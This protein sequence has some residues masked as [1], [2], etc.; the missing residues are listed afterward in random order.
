MKDLSNETISLFGKRSNITVL[1]ITLFFAML[2][3][4]L[5]IFTDG[6]GIWGSVDTPLLYHYSANPLPLP[7]DSRVD[8]SL[9][10]N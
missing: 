5:V 10:R 4:L 1:L 9:D 7:K 3:A 2:G 6:K 8:V